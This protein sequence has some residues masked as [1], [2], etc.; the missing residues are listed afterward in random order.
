MRLSIIDLNHD[1]PILSYFAD[2][3]LLIHLAFILYPQLGDNSLEKIALDYM[4]QEDVAVVTDVPMVDEAPI[5]EEEPMEPEDADVDLEV[6]NAPP[7]IFL[8]PHRK[9]P[10]KVKEK[11]DDSFLRRSKSIAN[12]LQGFKDAGSAKEAV[13][14]TEVVDDNSNPM[15]LAIIPPPATEVAPHLS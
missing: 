4:K 11:L 14:A 5:E 15:P 10:L 3:Q 9:K 6:L 8:T 13:D 12:K 7:A 1:L 2:D